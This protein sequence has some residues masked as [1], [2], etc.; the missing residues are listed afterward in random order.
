MNFFNVEAGLGGSIAMLMVDPEDAKDITS[1]CLENIPEES[2]FHE[3][4]KGRDGSPHITIQNGILATDPEEISDLDK[5]FSECGAIE[6]ELGDIDIF[7]REGKDYD[8]VKIS[9]ISEPLSALHDGID[10]LVEVNDPFPEYKPHI[11][12]AYVNR[13]EGRNWVGDK[14]FNGKKLTLDKIVFTGGEAPQKI[15][16]LEKIKPNGEPLK[17]MLDYAGPVGVKQ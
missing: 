13:G 10:T 1:W 17:E 11:T 6:V 14:S 2:V 9:V 3:E 4:G 7:Q 16:E 15:Y 5:L 8:V 12:L